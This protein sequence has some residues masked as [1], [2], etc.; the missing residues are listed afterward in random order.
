MSI[1]LKDCGKIMTLS[2]K[3]KENELEN[4]SIYIEKDKIKKLEK[5]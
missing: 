5:C 3:E 4:L 2:E 1:L